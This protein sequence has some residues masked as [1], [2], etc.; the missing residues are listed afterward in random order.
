MVQTN[1]WS[2]ITQSTTG[3]DTVGM[4]LWGKEADFEALR[5]YNTDAKKFVICFVQ[6]RLLFA[7]DR[8]GSC[9]SRAK[10]SGSSDSISRKVAAWPLRVCVW[11]WSCQE[12][13]SWCRLAIA[14]CKLSG[15]NMTLPA[16]VSITLKTAHAQECQSNSAEPPLLTTDTVMIIVLSS[17]KHWNFYKI[18]EILT[19]CFVFCRMDYKNQQHEQTQFEICTWPW[20]T[21]LGLLHW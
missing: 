9:V 17:Q 10:V 7:A 8:V 2:H 6:L 19:H 11:V 14:E 21:A 1:T 4:K 12:C 16:D 20:P 15:F 13:W 18:S 3:W 5:C